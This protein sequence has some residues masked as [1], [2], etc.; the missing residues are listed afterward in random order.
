MLSHI[1]RGTIN[2]KLNFI[3]KIYDQNED[4]FIDKKEML[5][6]VQAIYDM[7]GKSFVRTL[8]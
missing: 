8:F 2:E 1:T 4:E 7:L 6:I 3:F 5:T